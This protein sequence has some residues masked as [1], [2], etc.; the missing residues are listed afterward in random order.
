MEVGSDAISTL[1]KFLTGG[2]LVVLVT[3]LLKAYSTWRSGARV[4]TRS[5]VR[6]LVVDRQESEARLDERTIERDHWQRIAGGY[7]Y[8]L[9]THGITPDPEN[10]SPPTS[11]AMRKAIRRA[12]SGE[13]TGDILGGR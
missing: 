13:D 8:Q 3:Q 11:E 9:R 4:T 6:D 12:H 7:I 2:G 1:I 5:I 10:P